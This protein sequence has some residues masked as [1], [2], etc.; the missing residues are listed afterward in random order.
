M[1]SDSDVDLDQKTLDRLKFRILQLEREN[2]R[3]REYG[4]REM[5]D[6]IR[7]LIEEEVRKCY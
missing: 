3:A 6:K 2:L 4:N 5:V 7:K 1:K